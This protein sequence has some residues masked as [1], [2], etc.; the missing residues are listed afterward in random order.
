MKR[1]EVSFPLK[2]NPIFKLFSF[3]NDIWKD[4]WLDDYSDEHFLI[5]AIESHLTG[6]VGEQ[7]AYLDNTPMYPV[8]DKS[9]FVSC[10]LTNFSVKMSGLCD[11]F[12]KEQIKKF[13][14]D[15]LSAGKDNYNEEQFF[16]ALSEICVISYFCSIGNWKNKIYEPQINGKKNPEVRF[17]SQDEAIIDIEVKTPGFNQSNLNQRKLMPTVLLTQEGRL[18]IEEYCKNKNIK[19]LMPRVGKLKDFINSAAEKFEVPRDDNHLNLLFINWSYSEFAPDAYLEAYFLLVNPINGIIRNKDIGIQIGILEEA[20]DKISAI[21]V[22]SDSLNGLAYMDLRHIW[23]NRKFRM[24]AINQNINYRI[25]TG[26]NADPDPE[27]IMC[28]LGDEYTE[29]MQD[30]ATIQVMPIISQYILK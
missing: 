2:S 3:L 27:Q 10:F 22:Y 23:M 28:V 12:G 8:I 16:R 14:I 1:S 29:V 4:G 26:M 13:V 5:R 20:Y 25:L 15:Q 24:I 6:F 11:I 9:N 18:A 21:I 19:C 30:S 7:Q 17:V